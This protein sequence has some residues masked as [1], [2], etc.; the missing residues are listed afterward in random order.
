MTDLEQRILDVFGDHEL[1]TYEVQ[2]AVNPSLLTWRAVFRGPSRTDIMAGLWQLEE[3]R[4]LTS[5]RVDGPDGIVR[6]MYRLAPSP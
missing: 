6:W 5:R 4:R 2:K 1:S 3:Y